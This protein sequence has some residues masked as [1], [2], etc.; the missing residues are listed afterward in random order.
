MAI[1]KRGVTDKFLFQIFLVLIAALT[2]VAVFI[3]L[4]KLSSQPSE[5]PTLNNFK[6]LADSINS[7]V[8]D[9]KGAV[10][11][12]H[13]LF[14]GNNFIIAG[15]GTEQDIIN[16][17]CG[18]ERVVKPK[19]TECSGACM[20]LY[21]DNIGDD[22]FFQPEIRQCLSLDPRIKD[23]ITL[24]YYDYETEKVSYLDEN[25]ADYSRIWKNLGGG[26]LISKEVLGRFYSDEKFGNYEYSDFIV[27]GEC[28]DFGFSDESLGNQKLVIESVNSN[29][30]ATMLI[31][32]KNT[33]NYEERSRSLYDFFKG[34]S[35]ENPSG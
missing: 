25:D 19:K 27:Y 29:G 24:N 33:I 35:N 9:K 30:R 4:V 1:G 15:F 18:V 12:D 22:D 16:D 10:F 17:R 31:A 34:E 26:K 32:A 14:V 7:A 3:F 13:A 21:E 8:G 5:A 28:D 23:I 6:A 20:C 2:L 11:I